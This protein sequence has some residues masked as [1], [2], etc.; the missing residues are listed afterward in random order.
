MSQHVHEW[1]AIQMVRD[2]CTSECPHRVSTKWQLAR[3]YGSRKLQ[4]CHRT[5]LG[6]IRTDAA[7]S[8]ACSKAPKGIVAVSQLYAVPDPDQ[9]LHK[10]SKVADCR[11]RALLLHSIPLTKA[12]LL[13]LYACAAVLHITVQLQQPMCSWLQCSSCIKA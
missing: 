13:T 7:L 10:H 3:S 11:Q 6:S 5:S 4:T 1:H 9:L 12:V 8:A 2:I